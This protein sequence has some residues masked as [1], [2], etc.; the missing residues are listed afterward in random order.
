MT[1]MIACISPADSNIEE[2]TETLRYA[3]RT[4]NIK[5]SA[6]RN[7]MSSDALEEEKRK[8]E[9]KKDEEEGKNT[10]ESMKSQY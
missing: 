10:S 7:V 3:E 2:S 5:N 4:R 1:V 8:E 9:E 6:V